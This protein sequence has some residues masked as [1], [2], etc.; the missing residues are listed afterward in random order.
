MSALGAFTL[1]L[2]R[3]CS[4]RMLGYFHRRVL[5]G[6]IRAAYLCD[7]EVLSPRTL[8]RAQEREERLLIA[9]AQPRKPPEC[10]ARLASVAL[11]CIPKR[12]RFAI[13]HQPA[14][15]PD[16]PQRRRADSVGRRRHM[17]LHVRV[18]LAEVLYDGNL[19][20]VAGADVVQ[21][22]VAERMEEPVAECGRHRVGAAVELGA[23][24]YRH[25]VTQVTGCAADA[26]EQPRTFTR[27]VGV[28]ED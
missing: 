9:L 4:R 21:Q 24:G 10:V 20:P 1:S 14:S 6:V 19:D 26:V 27:S 5:R 12:Q 17:F 23:R 11:D 8:Q 25:D 2:S 3:G 16:A 15:Q 28:R 7:I 22:E 18:S 13:V